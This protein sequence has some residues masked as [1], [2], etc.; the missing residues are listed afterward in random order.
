MQTH[1]KLLRKP[2]VMAK[3]GLSQSELYHQVSTG[4]FP[5]PVHISARARAWVSSEIDQWIFSRIKVRD[6]EAV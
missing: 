2:E 1:E 3:T 6:G 5:K 4:E